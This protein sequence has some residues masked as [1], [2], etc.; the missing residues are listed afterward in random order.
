MKT[1]INLFIFLSITLQVYAQ[2]IPTLNAED[3]D[4]KLSS[5][6]ID[7]Q[8]VGNI[9]TTTYDMLFYNST[10]RILE[11]QLSFPLGQNQNVTRFALAI[12]N[13]LREAV[14]VEKELGRVVFETTVRQNIDPALLEKTKGNNYKARIYPIEPNSTKRVVLA[15]EQQLIYSKNA[16][17]YLLPLDFKDK[18]DV[19]SCKIEV[20]NQL[21][22]PIIKTRF[23]K[24]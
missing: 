17:Q 23:L 14:V 20:F 19:F 24:M 15:Y 16:H 3:G 18:L 21:L 7:V 9:A 2:S 10:D 13:K 6:K 1:I 8:V 5:L 4:L 11:G 22:E 12:N